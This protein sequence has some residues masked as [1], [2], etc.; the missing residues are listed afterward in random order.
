MHEYI[1]SLFI[2]AAKYWKQI[3][4]IKLQASEGKYYSAHNIKYYY[5]G[6]HH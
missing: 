5:S 1:E 4:T 2:I 6:D 3:K